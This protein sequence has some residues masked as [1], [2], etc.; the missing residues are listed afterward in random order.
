MAVS[1]IIPT[2]NEAASIAQTIRSLREQGADEVIVVDGGS[3]DGTLGLAQSADQIWTSPPGRAIQMN[4]GAK[5]A[6]GDVL[7][8]LHAD[9]KLEPGALTAIGR[10]LQS[11]RI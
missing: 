5:R 11:Q 2:W 8:F 4:A 10:T 7:L 9:C 3:G 1:I 6:T